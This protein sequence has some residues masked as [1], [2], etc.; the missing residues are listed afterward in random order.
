[1]AWYRAI[2]RFLRLEKDE[3]TYLAQ[4]DEQ[5]EQERSILFI[6]RTEDVASSLSEGEYGEIVEEGK[7]GLKIVLVGNRKPGKTTFLGRA[8]EEDQSLQLE[9]SNLASEF[10]KA[11]ARIDRLQSATNQ[12]KDETN[13]NLSVLTEVVKGL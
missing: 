9:L 6:E 7:E 3:A 5:Q 4:T 2:R 12:L 1:M 11:D 10:D 13:K 8:L